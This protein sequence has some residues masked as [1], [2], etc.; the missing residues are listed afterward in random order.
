ISRPRSP[1]RTHRSRW[2][3]PQA[4]TATSTSAGPGFGSGTSRSSSTSGPPGRSNTTAFT[5]APSLV[6]QHGGLLVPAHLP[7]QRL[8]AHPLVE[9]AVL[10]VQAAARVGQKL[11]RHVE[12][13]R[14]PRHDVP[15]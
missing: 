14:A 1:A 12:P 3:I 13:Q 10:L 8:L 11:Q 4:F 9:P 15:R 6:E 2:L 5:V 7:L